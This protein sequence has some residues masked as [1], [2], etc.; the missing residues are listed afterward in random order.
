MKKVLAV[1]GLAL[2][3]CWT[4]PAFADLIPNGTEGKKQRVMAT[5][6]STNDLNDVLNVVI[7]VSNRLGT[8][9]GFFYDINTKQTFNYAAATVYTEPNT[10]VAF[11]VGVLNLSGV[12]GSADYNLGNLVPAGDP[13]GNL[14]Q[15]AYVGF[16][17]GYTHDNELGNRWAYGPTA[18][19]KF[20]A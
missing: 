4:V 16:G 8:R 9:E 12:A 17:A 1:I 20:A 7:A 14:M 18:Q 2:A 19:V 13:L 15:Y 5:A 6:V 3:L 11:D 10:K